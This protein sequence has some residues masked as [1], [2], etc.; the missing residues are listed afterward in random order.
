MH[1]KQAKKKGLIFY[2]IQI[3]SGQVFILRS[4][5]PVYDHWVLNIFTKKPLFLIFR[6]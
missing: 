2:T 3:L 1:F 5:Y 4:F 6:I